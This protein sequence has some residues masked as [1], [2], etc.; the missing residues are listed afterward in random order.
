MFEDDM[1]KPEVG[2]RV[3]ENLEAWSV[4]DLRSLVTELTSEISRVESELERKQGRNA[5]AASLFKS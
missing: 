5:A 1:P 2:Y 4:E 3:G